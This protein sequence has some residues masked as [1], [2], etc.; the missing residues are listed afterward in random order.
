VD[1]MREGQRL[2]C[3]V[4]PVTGRERLF[5]GRAERQERLPKGLNIAVVGAGPAGLSYV[6]LVAGR[7]RVTVFEKTRV[8]G[9]AFRLA[10]LAPKFQ[11]VVADPMPL[12]RYVARLEARC[13]EAGA[14]FVLGS[15]VL[16]E[17]GRLA[18]FDLVVLA[19]GARYRPGL[20]FLPAL[21]RAGL[22]RLPFVRR[23]AEQDAWRDW[24]Y[25][26]ARRSQADAF[27][28]KLG[29]AKVI[30]IGDALT[31]GKSVAAIRSAFEAAYG[32][33]IEAAS[34]AGGAA[35]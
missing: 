32:V 24:F 21:L 28:R 34:P 12:L 13:R 11:N 19:T 33:S 7:N 10:G 14:T 30:V 1:G 8:A 25:Y 4:N 23:R 20:G 15:D 31:P 17:P 35:S 3:L 18:E 27:R 2:H 6:S 29:S 26:R 9:G 5:G 16:A 22:A